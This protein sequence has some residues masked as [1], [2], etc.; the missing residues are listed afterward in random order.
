MSRG[1]QQQEHIEVEDILVKHKTLRAVL[2]IQDDVEHWVPL[3]QVDGEPDVG[4]TSIRLT[5]WI[6]G[7]KNIE[8][9]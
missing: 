5:P 9:A 6:I 7:E 3:S 4:D 8:V 1:R 2:I